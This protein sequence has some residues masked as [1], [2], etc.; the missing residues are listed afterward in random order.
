MT[1]FPTKLWQN[2]CGLFI[3]FA[4]VIFGMGNA[5][6]DSF[7]SSAEVQLNSFSVT[8]P[9]TL[10]VNQP[11]QFSYQVTADFSGQVEGCD[12]VTNADNECDGNAN[13]DCRIMIE[14]VSFPSAAA[15]VD[16][17]ND[18]LDWFTYYNTLGKWIGTTNDLTDCATTHDMI[19]QTDTA[20]QYVIQWTASVTIDTF[21]GTER[22]AY[23]DEST[24]Q[25]ITFDVVESDAGF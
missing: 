4:V 6:I 5:C 10:L 25:E 14:I 15:T 3:F 1:S 17:S 11:N 9:E 24:S 2:S 21:L 18:D 12:V 20:G 22:G 8:P 19:F 7:D 13:F 16:F 23:G